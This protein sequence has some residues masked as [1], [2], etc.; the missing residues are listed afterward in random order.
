L[1]TPCPQ[2]SPPTE[3]IVRYPSRTE[4][5]AGANSFSITFLV[6]VFGRV[7]LP[8]LAG[9][10]ATP[11]SRVSLRVSF[12]DSDGVE[13]AIRDSHPRWHRDRA[14]ASVLAHE[15]DDAPAVVTLLDIIE[16]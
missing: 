10:N 14:H 3:R 5:L 2:W 6:P 8:P 4:V 13:Y 1:V 11:D 7:H 9:G 12:I 15:V 16:R